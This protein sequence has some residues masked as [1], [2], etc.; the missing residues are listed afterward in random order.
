MIGLLQGS[1]AY[2][3][4]YFAKSFIDVSVYVYIYICMFV[5]LDLQFVMLF[6]SVHDSCV[7]SIE[8]LLLLGLIPS[9]W[10]MTIAK[11]YLLL[12]LCQEFLFS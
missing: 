7:Y 10:I 9:F 4:N 11:T 2:F 5:C 1:V 8:L 12:L 6:V 3:T